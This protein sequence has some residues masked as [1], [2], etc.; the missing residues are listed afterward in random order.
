MPLVARACAAALSALLEAQKSLDSGAVDSV[1]KLTRSKEAKA[2]QTAW[3][4][5]Y[6]TVKVSSHRDPSN[7]RMRQ[8]LSTDSHLVSWLQSDGIRKLRIPSLCGIHRPGVQ[9]PRIIL[10]L[11]ERCG[12]RWLAKHRPPLCGLTMLPLCRS[13]LMLHLE[14]R[15]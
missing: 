8:Q 2:F 15:R 13:T 7:S 6:A 14:S 4:S 12:S 9:T 3:K 1:Q 5:L 11:I 10:G